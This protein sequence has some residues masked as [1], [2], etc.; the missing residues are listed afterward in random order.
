[1]TNQSPAKTYLKDYEAPAFLLETTYLDVSLGAEITEV[2]TTYKVQRNPKNVQD[3]IVLTGDNIDLQAVFLNGEKLEDGQFTLNEDTSEVSRKKGVL[4]VLNVADSFELKVVNHI[5][6]QENKSNSGLYKSG[7]MFC[8]QCESQGFR[9]IS[10]AID[11]PDVMSV[12]TVKITADKSKYP[13]LLSNGDLVDSIQN[14]DGTHT[15]IWHD[16]HKKPTYLFALVAGDMV[17]VEDNFTTSSGKNVDI[18]F[19]ADKDVAPEELIFGVS[20]LK[21]SMKW[22]E[23]TFGLEYDLGLY[24][25]VASK[26]FNMGAMENKGLNVFNT[27]YVLGNEKSATDRDLI[28]IDAVIA[29][30]YFHNWTGNRVTCRDWFQLSLKEGLTVF[31]DARYTE[32]QTDPLTKRIDDV[33][34][35]R[36]HQFMEDA[37]PNAHPIRPQFFTTIRN[38]YTVTVY[39]KGAEVIRMIYNILGKEGFRKGMDLYFARHDGEAVTTED[40]VAAMADANGVDFEQFKNW[41]DQG[42]TPQMLV[43]ESYDEQTQTFSLT[44]KQSVRQIEGYPQP[45]PF[46][47]PVAIG[48]LDKSGN[49]LLQGNS[50]AF[51]EGTEVLDFKEEEQTFTFNNIAEKPVLSLLRNF[52][53]P[54]AVERAVSDDDLMFLLKHDNDAFNRWDAGQQLMQACLVDMYEGKVSAVPAWLVD[55]LSEILADDTLDP[56]VKNEML[57]WPTEV[58]LHQAIDSVDVQKVHH[59]REQAVNEVS[60]AL[61]PQ[62]KQTYEAYTGEEGK[63]VRSLRNYC[64]AMLCRAGEGVHLAQKQLDAFTN[65]NMT[66]ELSALSCLVNYA[67]ESLRT[68]VLDAFYDRWK[69]YTDVVDSWL[70]VQTGRDDEYILKTVKSLMDSDV[71]DVKNP[72]KVR[73]VLG[74]YFRNYAQY[75]TEEGYAFHA[76]EILRIDT[77]NPEL[78][79]RLSAGLTRYK[80]F[81]PKHAEAMKAQLQR[82]MA[83][84]GLS[85]DVK[86]IVGNALK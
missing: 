53:A 85:V 22:D 77:F 71:V 24:Q 69:N 70:S 16:P 17:R 42:G 1:M 78:A 68:S 76:N 10:Y 4:T 11:R 23:D 14:D 5:K 7:E 48:L 19:Y 36:D 15:A 39:E 58:T 63:N 46:H 35:M 28:N 50:S 59:V 75:H 45:K 2:V 25:V 66:N 84:E 32:D 33:R 34:M 61:A 54:V 57:H 47:I 13:Y 6:P 62:F 64:L 83:T 31:R 8:T 12:F 29:H 43:A 20:C 67:D 37:G 21:K 52:S 74:G 51:V 60:K 56:A 18:H 81:A 40:F 72:N 9:R 80:M 30:E 55:A 79:S 27:A 38:F 49:E 3:S 82:I 41:Y 26:D 73:A 65:K 44:L 86:E